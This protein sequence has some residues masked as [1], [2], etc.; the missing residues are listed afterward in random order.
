MPTAETV[1]SISENPQDPGATVKPK[2]V[3]INGIRF[4]HGEVDWE[5][6]YCMTRED[7]PNFEAMKTG[8]SYIGSKFTAIGLI[9]QIGQYLLVITEKND[10]SKEYDYSV[11]PLH[12]KTAVRFR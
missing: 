1:I 3:V 12:A 6:A 10:E 9:A 11:I 4:R 7:L 2:G 5:D 8:N